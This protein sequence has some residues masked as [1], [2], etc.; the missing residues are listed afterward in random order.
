MAES[1]TLNSA[2]DLFASAGPTEATATLP[3]GRTVRFRGQSERKLVALQKS[4]VDAK[5]RVRESRKPEVRARYVVA[6]AVND[7]GKPLF[8]VDDV[9]RLLEMDAAYVAAMFEAASKVC[10]LSEADVEELAGNSEKTED[11]GS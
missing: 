8:T 1:K 10:G 11:G 7:E 2:D 3:N 4:F 5:G 9:P 6:Y